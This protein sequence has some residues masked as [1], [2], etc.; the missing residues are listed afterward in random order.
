VSELRELRPEDSEAVAA[1]FHAAFGDERPMDAE[2]IRSW[3]RNTEL[4]PSW[5]RVLEED[6]RIVGYA[7]IWP[8]A[9]DVAVDVAAPGRWEPFLDWA[10]SHARAAAIPR[11]RVFL[12]AGFDPAALLLGRGYRLWR[13]AYTM[14]IDLPERPAEPPLPAGLVVRPYAPA[15]EEPLLASLNEA[16]VEDPF[17]HAVSPAN[18]RE[19]YLRA[20]GFDPAL[21][22]LAWDG[23]RLAGSALAYGRHGAE[24][25]LGWVGT[26]SVR[27]PWRKRGLGTALLRRAFGVLYDRGLRRA[28]L[29]VDAENVTGALR[30]Y[31]GA[32]MRRV[33]QGDNWVLEL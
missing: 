10:E 22:L 33:R 11:V 7:D 32:G 19:F 1:L 9:D 23:E 28:G 12:P 8:T 25:D 3:T 13:S 27:V 5:L 14:E 6:G 24:S 15:D 20:R 21:W 2:E 16:F 29:G 18:F 30:I 26:L 17:W 31:E 4:Q